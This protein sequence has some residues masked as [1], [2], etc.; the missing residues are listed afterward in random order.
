MSAVLPAASGTRSRIGFA[1]YAC[2]P[3]PPQSAKAAMT[4]S[5]AATPRAV[6]K[7]G[8]I[9]GQPSMSTELQ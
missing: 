5:A 7:F 3:A 4:P 8:T 9:S 6:F 1:G 2:A